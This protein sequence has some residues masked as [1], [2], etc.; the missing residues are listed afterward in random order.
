MF[1][2]FMYIDEV[3]KI[4]NGAAVWR[5]GKLLFHIEARTQPRFEALSIPD[6]S[7]IR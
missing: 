1:N 5:V 6:F 2:L 3:A 4:L 7:P